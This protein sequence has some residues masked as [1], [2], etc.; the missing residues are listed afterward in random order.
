MKAFHYARPQNLKEALTHQGTLK[1]GG[2]DLLSRMKRGTFAPKTLIEIGGLKE[3]SFA[4][5][6]KDGSLWIGAALPLAQLLDSKKKFPAGIS[7]A[8]KGTAT[9]QIRNQA[10]VVGNLL[11]EKR[12]LYLL[13]PEISCLAKGGKGC[14]AK[15]GCHAELAFFEPGS[16]LAT[17]SSNM[18]PIFCALNARLFSV[19]DK[20]HERKLRDFY[21]SWGKTGKRPSLPLIHSILLPGESLQGGSAHHEI[22]VKQSFDWASASAAAHILRIGDRIKKVSLWLGSV[23]GIPYQAQVVEEALQGQS[24]PDFKKAAALLK[25][26]AQLHSP[27]QEWKKKMALLCAEKALRK[28][29]DNA[30]EN[31]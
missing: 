21:Q 4:P 9:P 17:Q 26:K 3:I 19:Q 25:G 2:I 6:Q 14:P 8:A 31:R 24:S 23:A 16:C 18:A 13:D 30:K 11:Q 7:E 27:Q 28:A 20:L 12:C 10:T 15:N 5:Y 29:Y 1:A 22:R